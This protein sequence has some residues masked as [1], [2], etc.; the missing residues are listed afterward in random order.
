MRLL[1]DIETDGLLDQMT[2]IHCLVIKDLDSGVVR[3]YL[4][5]IEEP[6]DGCLVLGLRD[7]HEADLIAGHNI[8]GF[9][10]PAIQKAY[11]WFQPKGQIRDTLLLSRL[12]WSDLKERDFELV[13]KN[14]AFPKNLIGSH[15][16]KAWGYRLGCLKGTYG[17]TND[18]STFSQEMLDYCVQDVEVTHKLWQ[19]IESKNYS[20]QAIE[21]EHQ[22]AAVIRLQE[23]HGFG[24]DKAKAVELY[25][26]LGQRRLELE[27][28]LAKAC[29]GWSVE[30]KTPDGYQVLNPDGGVAVFQTRADAEKMGKKWWP[31][32]DLRRLAIARPNKRKAIPFNPSSRDHIA[33]FLI[34]R[35]GWKPTKFT[36]TG[37]PE[38]DESVLEALV[39]PEAKLLSEYFMVEKRIGQ[40]AEGQNSWLKLEQNGRIHGEVITNG[41]VTGRCTHSRPNVAQVPACG[42]PYGREC[43]A[44]FIPRPGYSLVGWDASG[45][46]LRCLAHFMAAWDDGAYAKEL[47]TGDIHT[48]NQK[49]AG[50][51][52]RNNA[53]TFI[54]AFLYGAG[55]AKI[56]SIVNGGAKEG[57]ALKAQ[58]LAKTPAL[59]KL[60]T[61]VSA[62]AKQRG[63]LI[64]LDGRHLPIRSEHAALNTLL[65]SAGAVVMKKAKVIGYQRLL[66]RGLKWGQDWAQVASIHDEG[67]NEVRIGLE[68]VVGKTY[69][70]SLTAAGEAFGFKCRLDGEYKSGASWAATH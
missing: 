12:I 41:A 64:G 2:K 33:R 22:F 1:F 61:A 18:W 27:K 23:R 38:I 69:V 35:Y 8:Q 54:Y 50:L 4:G 25:A 46:E 65:Q 10:I 6:D 42:V 34:E 58:F 31:K 57:K 47:L 63:Y 32:G 44:L 15:G 5:N 51:P 3:R 11:P 24:F 67:Q 68:D 17:E 52:T 60:K 53:K 37:K 26:K 36:E 62:R 19:L 14:E 55:D 43:R 9:D 45:L 40:I 20:E 56:G 49:A 30:M 59:A 13:K 28:E 7:L 66:E 39:Y 48:A 70:E 16:L 21:L 29:P